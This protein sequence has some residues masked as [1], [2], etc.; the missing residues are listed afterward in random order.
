VRKVAGPNR[1]W[2]RARN[3]T[4]F[5]N[6]LLGVAVVGGGVGVFAVAVII[7]IIIMD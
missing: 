3:R 6:T 1:S 2:V 4:S 7:I 5:V